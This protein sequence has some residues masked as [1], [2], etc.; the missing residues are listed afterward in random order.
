[1]KIKTKGRH[2]DTVEVMEAAVLKTLTGHD[3]P[4]TFKK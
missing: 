1:M 4:N 2:F 3:F